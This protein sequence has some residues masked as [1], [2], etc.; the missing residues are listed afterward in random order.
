MA[1]SP[2]AASSPQVAPLPGGFSLHTPHRP[3][4]WQ[5]G[6]TE[7]G[8]LQEPLLTA[9]S[10]GL[11]IGMSVGTPRSAYTAAASNKDAAA[12]AATIAGG[13]APGAPVVVARGVRGE[14]RDTDITKALVFGEPFDEPL[15]GCTEPEQQGKQ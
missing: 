10:D 1:L 13:A 6:S 2:R 7:G 3:P 12:A 14:E 9:Q 11:P 4:R 8:E 15:A 5:G